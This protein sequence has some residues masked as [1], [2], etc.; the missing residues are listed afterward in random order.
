MTEPC[1]CSVEGCTIRAKCR[2]LCNKHYAAWYRANNRCKQRAIVRKDEGVRRKL[3]AYA[4]RSKQIAEHLPGTYREL[5]GKI[6]CSVQAVEYHSARMRKD[7]LCHV[8]SYRRCR[9]TGGGYQ[10][11]L[12]AGPGQ[13]AQC[14]LKALDEKT[15]QR[16]FRA[17]EKGSGSER[18]IS[19]L[20]RL[21]AMNL[22]KRKPQPDPLVGLFF[23]MGRP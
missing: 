13:D 6:G 3:V 12:V 4:E 15:Y 11:V 5:A 20:N 9:G 14:K 19:N 23:N 1:Q 21:K 7:G 10:P 17:K 2:A 18:E 8:G 16:R 22:M